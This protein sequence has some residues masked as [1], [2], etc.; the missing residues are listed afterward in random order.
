MSCTH[1][2]M[3]QAIGCFYD[4]GCADERAHIVA[5]LRSGR[6][7]LMFVNEAADAIER[8]DHLEHG[9]GDK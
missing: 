7:L 4:Q 8:G 2:E 1:G 6:A 3:C 9:K 5:W